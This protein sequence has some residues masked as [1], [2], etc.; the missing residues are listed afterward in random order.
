M[1]PMATIFPSLIATSPRRRGAPSP[2]ENQTVLDNDV[3]ILTSHWILPCHVIDLRV[4]FMPPQL[5]IQV[6]LPSGGTRTCVLPPVT[7]RVRR[8]RRRD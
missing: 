5:T 1:R 7:P 2:V 6:T 4:I 8:V 3:V